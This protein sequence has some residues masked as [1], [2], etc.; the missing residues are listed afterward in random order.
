MHND[1]TCKQYNAAGV[2]DV[3]K[4]AC[5][6]DGKWTDGSACTKTGQIG[7]CQNSAVKYN[8]C[9]Y[10]GNAGSLKSQCEKASGVWCS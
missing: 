9:Y 8:T 1:N 10:T 6:S 5:N 7:C 3:L 2:N 4:N